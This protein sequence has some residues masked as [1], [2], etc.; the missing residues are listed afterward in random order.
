LVALL[1]VEDLGASYALNRYGEPSNKW[2][3]SCIAQAPV[4]GQLLK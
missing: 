1:V 2:L 3:W 4:V